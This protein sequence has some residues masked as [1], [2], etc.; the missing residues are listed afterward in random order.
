MGWTSVRVA[1]LNEEWTL[2]ECGCLRV[3]PGL[4]LFPVPRQRPVPRH[5]HGEE[6]RSGLAYIPSPIGLMRGLRGNDTGVSFLI[7]RG[8]RMMWDDVGCGKGSY[9]LWTWA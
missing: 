5:L 1:A 6:S 7:V 9:W 4:Q 8:E 2:W 3:R